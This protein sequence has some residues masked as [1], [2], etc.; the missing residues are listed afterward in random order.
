[1]KISADQI[2]DA[3]REASAAERGRVREFILGYG[4]GP[5]S[6]DAGDDSARRVAVLDARV[7]GV[8]AALRDLT[9]AIGYR[10]EWG[11]ERSLETRLIQR[12]DELS[13]RIDTLQRGLDMLMA[14]VY[15]KE[16]GHETHG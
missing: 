9:L 13:E 12:D 15:G 14:R 3:Y 4:D 5:A 11:K 8:A 6:L 16:H 10:P 2:M 1:M 7:S